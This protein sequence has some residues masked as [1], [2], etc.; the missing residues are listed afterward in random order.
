MYE[1]VCYI[2][3]PEKA[4]FGYM[5]KDTYSA[6]GGECVKGKKIKKSNY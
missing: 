6:T 3:A 4:D 5:I 2:L 1:K